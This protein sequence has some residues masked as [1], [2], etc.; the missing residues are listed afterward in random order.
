[1]ISVKGPV[2]NNRTTYVV[3]AI[4]QQAGI[5]SR[6]TLKPEIGARPSRLV[7]NGLTAGL[8]LE[9]PSAGPAIASSPAPTGSYPAH[10]RWRLRMHCLMEKSPTI[11]QQ[12]AILSVNCFQSIE[13]EFVP[14]SPI[15]ICSLYVTESAP[16]FCTWYSLL[17]R[18]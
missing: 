5:A 2:S 6:K 10:L 18:M 13:R 17:D 11:S 7:T 1:M 15:N 8:G 4:S 9:V 12:P 3:P 14:I 16:I